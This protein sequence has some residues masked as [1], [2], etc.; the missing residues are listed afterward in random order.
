M[1]ESELPMMISP[2]HIRH[3]LDLLRQSLMCY[4][5][6]TVEQKDE[7][8]GGVHGFGVMHRCKKW[9]ELLRW[10][11]DAQKSARLGRLKDSSN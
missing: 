9:D 5:D 3:C 1:N 11:A 10:T 8:A 2:P 6:T 7:E 4:P